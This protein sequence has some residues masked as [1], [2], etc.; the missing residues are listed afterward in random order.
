MKTGRLFSLFL[1]GLFLPLLSGCAGNPVRHPNRHE[2]GFHLSSA[3]ELLS[4][5]HPQQAAEAVKKALNRHRIAVDLAGTIGDMNR[6]A[7]L[8][9]LS[10][11]VAEARLWID[12]ALVLESVSNFPVQHIETHLLAAEISLPENKSGP[13]LSEAKKLIAA[14]PATNAGEKDRLTSRYLQIQ[15]LSLSQK[16]A[17][18]AAIDSFSRALTLDRSENRTR[19][20]ATDLANLGRNDF[21]IGNDRDA[22]K[23]FLEAYRLD[24]DLRNSSGI[25]FDLEGISLVDARSGHPRTAARKMLEAAG[26]QSAIGRTDSARKDVEFVRSVLVPAGQKDLSGTGGVLD[27]W[28][29]GE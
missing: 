24:R 17:Y 21:L 20:I 25:A 27:R 14:L 23:D 1:A 5:N 6:L 18:R 7:H 2:A 9:S 26:L 29:Q 13:W 22:K 8:E 28:F 10:G 3:Q 16:G 15:G 12:K 19:S 4:E 11:N